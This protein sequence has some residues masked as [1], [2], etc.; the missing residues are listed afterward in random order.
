MAKII[1][2][3]SKIDTAKERSTKTNIQKLSE[4][5]NLK[6][7]NKSLAYWGVKK[8]TP[9]GNPIRSYPD[10][11]TSISGSFYK[12]APFTASGFKI[13]GADKRGVVN[14][15]SVQYKWEQ[16]SYSSTTA[17]GSFKNPVIDLKK[18]STKLDS[19]T[20][21]VPEKIRY[22]N[23]SKDSCKNTDS[24]ELATLHNKAFSFNKKITV[25]DLADNISIVFTPAKNTANTHLRIVMQFFRIV[26]EYT[27]YKPTKG[28][29]QQIVTEGTTV[30]DEVEKTPDFTISTSINKTQ[31]L[32]NEE[33][34]YTI[35]VQNIEPEGDILEDLPVT[36]D[37]PSNTD[38]N[39]VDMIGIG[40]I[41]ISRTSQWLIKSFE[42]NSAKLVLRCKTRTSNNYAIFTASF[43]YPPTKQY[44]KAD[45]RIKIIS[46]A[47][48]F[49]FYSTLSQSVYELNT[50]PDC[51]F[52]LTF[53]S[54]I[55]PKSDAVIT[56]ETD[57]FI[58]YE[59][60]TGHYGDGYWLKDSNDYNFENN[61]H[62]NK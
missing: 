51:N 37:L 50:A 5:N 60:S 19:I 11:L 24:A 39:V 31:A 23:C 10:S 61:K 40:D 29:K 2:Y 20:G 13:S 22:D 52:I 34:D 4:K 25:G 17:Y 48:N 18:G 44:N 43:K 59:S 47:I 8:P 33:Y 32:V 57:N 56:I 54:E 46:D 9:K 14:K 7:A 35:T 3:P 27:P 26:V 58:N 42:D 62:K 6:S 41:N 21:S 49:R 16:I 15:I 28:E 55:I 36:I 30:F 12:P 53:G 45:S 38:V 1:L